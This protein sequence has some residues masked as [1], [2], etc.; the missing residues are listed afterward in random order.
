MKLEEVVRIIKNKEYKGIKV[1]K[2]CNKITVNGK[3]LP[4]FILKSNSKNILVI[5]GI[6]VWCTN[7]LEIKEFYKLLME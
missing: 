7:N 5:T 2:Q 3:Y 6:E 1:N 4:L